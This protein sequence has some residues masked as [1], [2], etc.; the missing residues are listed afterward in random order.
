MGGK[1]SAASELM[2]FEIQKK[3]KLP[4]ADRYKRI[5]KKKMEESRAKAL[6]NVSTGFKL[7]G[8]LK[9]VRKISK[10]AEAALK[11]IAARKA[12]KEAKAL[13]RMVIVEQRNFQNGRI[14]KNG[15]IYDI[16]GNLV[17]EVKLKN[18]KM[19]TMT[20]WGFGQ[21]KAKNYL[22]NIAIQDAIT[23]YSPYYINM[24]KMQAM[25]T[26]QDAPDVINVHGPKTTP[27]SNF[28]GYQGSDAGAA[29][30]PY[31]EDS[32][33]P[34]QNIGMTSWGARSDNVWGTFTDNAWGTSTDNVWGSNSTDIWG[35]I[36]GNIFGGKYIQ[37]WGT[38]NGKNY[39]KGL[40]GFFAALFGIKTKKSREAFR[41]NVAKVRA[42]RAAAAAVART[43]SART[44]TRR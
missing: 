14:E 42:G 40:T 10:R 15:K 7:P 31:G 36:G 30:S 12:A 6:S 23:K 34:R 35:G 1:R 41:A 26:M 16:A 28:Y 24:R 22:T 37:V 27:A 4:A 29:F 25:Q 17:G 38:G 44:S 33:G 3:G 11:E 5:L 20:G 8:S 18:G 39:L 9:D 21:Y 19:Q 13:R 32:L 2:R 43:S